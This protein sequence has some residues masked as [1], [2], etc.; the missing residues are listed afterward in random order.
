[1]LQQAGI[2]ALLSFV[3]GGDTFDAKKPDPKP[4]L[5]AAAEFGAK[6]KQCVMIGD[7]VNDHAAAN[8][9]GFGFIFARYGYSAA[10]DP[11]LN[12]GLAAIDSFADMRE[13]LC[14]E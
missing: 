11:D 2:E 6:P 1:L 9:A 4:L 3:Y 8:A 7:S 14:R 13:L 10:D 5:M 12:N